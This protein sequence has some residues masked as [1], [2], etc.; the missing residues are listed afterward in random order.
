MNPKHIIGK[1]CALHPELL[2]ERHGKGQHHCI[3]CIRERNLV[4]REKNREY[5]LKRDSEYHAN[6]RAAR[7]KKS[8]DRFAR[9]KEAYR[10]QARRWGAEN[11]ER[12]AANNKAWAKRNPEKF[13]SSV[14][15]N[16]IIR[17][18]LIGGQKLARA[19]A[20]EI[21]Q[22][23]INCPPNHHVDHV[24][25]L[26]GRGVNGLHVPWNLQ[27]LPATE[28]MRKGNRIQENV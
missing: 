15:V 10:E 11:K 28:N 4:W 24:I 8:A 7:I 20:K 12:K 17:K 9:N 2:G 23:Y 25:P 5:A 26:R 6:N 22:I 19:Y 13:M 18:R 3:A 16:N 14:K 27:Y 21:R 1:V